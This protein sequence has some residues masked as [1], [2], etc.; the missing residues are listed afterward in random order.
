[1]DVRRELCDQFIAA[2]NGKPPWLTMVSVCTV[3]EIEHY[4]VVSSGIFADKFP[5][6]YPH[7]WTKLALITL[8]E[9]MEAYMVA[10]AKCILVT[11]RLQE[12]LR[13]CGVKT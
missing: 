13:G 3:C 11:G 6:K 7:V 5:D 12:C 2:L 4:E 8:E 1:V 10:S 9:A